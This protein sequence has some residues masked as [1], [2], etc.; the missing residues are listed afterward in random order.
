MLINIEIKKICYHLLNTPS[1]IFNSSTQQIN[2][3]KDFRN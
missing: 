1:R 3:R 2:A